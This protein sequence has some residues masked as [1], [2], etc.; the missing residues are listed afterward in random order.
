[1]ALR[2]AENDIGMELIAERILHSP[3][4]TFIEQL[5]NPSFTVLE[6]GSD[7]HVE[8]LEF[9]NPPVHLYRR[10]EDFPIQRNPN[11]LF[12]DL[13]KTVYKSSFECIPGDRITVFT[14]SITDRFGG[15]SSF[16]GVIKSILEENPYLSSR[17]LIH[18]IYQSSLNSDSLYRSRSNKDPALRWLLCTCG[19]RASF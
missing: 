18:R 8:V 14:G 2:L 7:G 6:V 1:M 16:N 12:D 4:K 19:I 5:H 15:L 3:E 13:A 10:G 9:G 17:E 11:A